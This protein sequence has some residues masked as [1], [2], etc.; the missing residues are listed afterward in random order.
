ME[1]LTDESTMPWGKHKG[2]KMEEVPADYLLFC[3]NE[4]KACIRV[5]KYVEENMDVLKMQAAEK[6]K[7]FTDK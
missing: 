5:R 3:Y 4:N 1:K 6:Q 2:K 7:F